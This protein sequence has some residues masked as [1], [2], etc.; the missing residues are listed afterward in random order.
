M[1]HDVR[2]PSLLSA[3]RF[4]S[5]LLPPT[6]RQGERTSRARRAARTHQL[7]LIRLSMLFALLI[8]HMTKFLVSE[9]ARNTRTHAKTSPRVARPPASDKQTD[10]FLGYVLRELVQTMDI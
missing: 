4:S 2:L 6:T 9:R 10:V 8:I 3:L 7:K 5:N 1:A